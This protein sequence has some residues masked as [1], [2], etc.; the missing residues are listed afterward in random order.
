MYVSIKGRHEQSRQSNDFHITQHHDQS[1]SDLA[2]SCHPCPQVT[3]PH[4][5]LSSTN[6]TRTPT[7]LFL[8]NFKFF[9]I[10]FFF[11]VA[12]SGFFCSV[13]TV[14][15]VCWFHLYLSVLRCHPS[16]TCLCLLTT[17]LCV[18]VPPHD[19]KRMAWNST[20]N[21]SCP[22]SEL[23]QSSM[24][25]APLG[26]NT[27]AA[28]NN[29]KQSKNTVLTNLTSALPAVYSLWVLLAF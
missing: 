14:C 22:D 4:A 6:P 5:C 12:H 2:S 11:F 27:V 13:L 21:S 29:T 1:C 26:S 10:I 9:S 28:V 20:G 25:A 7:L 23:S 15:C 19:V 18:S 17:P 16:T 3:H 8:T 24:P